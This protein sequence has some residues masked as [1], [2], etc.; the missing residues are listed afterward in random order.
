MQDKDAAMTPVACRRLVAG[1][2]IT[3]LRPG[4]VFWHARILIALGIA[5]TL[6]L[7]TLGIWAVLAAPA[8]MIR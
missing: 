6:A 5:V 3:A 2:T 4:R 1:G 7:M 8:A